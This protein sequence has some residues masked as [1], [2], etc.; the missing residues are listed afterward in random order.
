M[1]RGFS[2]VELM[3]TLFIA[4]LFILSGYQLY[5]AVIAN[6]KDAREM[7]EASNVGYEVLRKEGAVY[8]GV[9]N[10]PCNTPRIETI[11]RTG[12]KLQNVQISLERCKPFA[13]SSLIQVTAKIRYGVPQKEVIHATYVA[14]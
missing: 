6:S 3:V 2:V 14:G 7:S 4:T 11:T 1:S 5:G 8:T 12:L 9:V 10:E 13:S